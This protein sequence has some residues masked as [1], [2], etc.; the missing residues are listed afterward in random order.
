MGLTPTQMWVRHMQIIS[1]NNT[2]VLIGPIYMH[3]VM[4]ITVFAIAE[5]CPV[6][7]GSA[8]GNLSSSACIA[9]SGLSRESATIQAQVIA[10]GSRDWDNNWTAASASASWLF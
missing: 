2:L 6:I 9:I 10:C 8:K 4:R 3:Y 7:K 1:V 5:V